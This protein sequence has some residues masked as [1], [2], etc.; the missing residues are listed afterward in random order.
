VDA[1]G[2]M[3]QKYAVSMSNYFPMENGLMVRG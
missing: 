3:D 2:T 1:H